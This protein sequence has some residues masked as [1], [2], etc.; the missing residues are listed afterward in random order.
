MEHQFPMQSEVSARRRQNSFRFKNISKELVEHRVFR[1][2][3]VSENGTH[4]LAVAICWCSLHP[5]F[6]LQFCQFCRCRKFQHLSICKLQ[7]ITEIV[8]LHTPSTSDFW[9][10]PIHKNINFIYTSLLL[11]AFGMIPCF[12][13]RNS[14]QFC[15]VEWD[16]KSLL[17]HKKEKFK[18][19]RR[20]GQIIAIIDE[21]PDHVRTDE[22]WSPSRSD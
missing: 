13:L 2:C 11:C 10:Y 8:H 4:S 14:R 1:A 9:T 21:E 19:L 3:A 12:R 17:V 20:C 7:N 15:K 6:S 16:T 5:T 22:D 18:T